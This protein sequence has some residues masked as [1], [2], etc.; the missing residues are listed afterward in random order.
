MSE[1]EMLE[2]VIGIG[3]GLVIVISLKKFIWWYTR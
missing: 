3:L 2:A 1:K